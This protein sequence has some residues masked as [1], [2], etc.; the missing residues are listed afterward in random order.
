MGAL[1]LVVGR[2]ITQ[3]KNPVRAADAILAEIQRAKIEAE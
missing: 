1:Y 2:P 3:S